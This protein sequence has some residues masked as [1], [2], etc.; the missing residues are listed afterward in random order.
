MS[1]FSGNS[2][3]N[4]TV[5]R[6]V[7]LKDFYFLQVLS[8]W[9]LRSWEL[10]MHKWVKLQAFFVV[11][12]SNS[13][14]AAI[15]LSWWSWRKWIEVG[16]LLQAYVEIPGWVRGFPTMLNYEELLAVYPWKTLHHSRFPASSPDLV[17]QSKNKGVLLWGVCVSLNSTS[18]FFQRVLMVKY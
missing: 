8:V 10:T 9:S 6:S 7:V 5:I 3:L 11:T 12:Y 2:K 17:F 13:A 4:Y 18:I 14:N 16:R 1:W 15:K